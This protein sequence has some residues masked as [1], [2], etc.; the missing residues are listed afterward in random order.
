MGSTV[1]SRWILDM[2]RVKPVGFPGSLK[3]E[4]EREGRIK[5]YSSFLVC[6]QKDGFAFSLDGGAYGWRKITTEAGL[7]NFDCLRSTN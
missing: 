7:V 5:V 1:S 4:W 3:V 2:L 6:N